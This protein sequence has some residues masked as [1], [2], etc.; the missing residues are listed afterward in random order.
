MRFNFFKKNLKKEESTRTLDIT[1][2]ALKE[3]SKDELIDIILNLAK[4]LKMLEEKVAKLSKNSSNSSKPPSSD[5][6][7]PKGKSSNRNRSGQK[8]IRGAQNGHQKAARRY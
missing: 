8:R 5:I 6:T 4:Q 3:K 1:R 2:S 7:N